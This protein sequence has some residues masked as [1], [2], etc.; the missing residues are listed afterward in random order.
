MEIFLKTAALMGVNPCDVFV[1]EDAKNGII[2]D[3]DYI[4]TEYIL[5]EKN[6]RETNFSSVIL[7]LFK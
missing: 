4:T 2:V 3:K 1:F 5:Q 6:D 7:I